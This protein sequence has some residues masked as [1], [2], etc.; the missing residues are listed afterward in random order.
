ML[1]YEGADVN[2]R[3]EGHGTALEIASSKG[4]ALIMQ[5]MLEKNVDIH[6]ER[7]KFLSAI[8]AAASCVNRDLCERILVPLLLKHV[9][10]QALAFKISTRRWRMKDDWETLLPT[11][12]TYNPFRRYREI[13]EHIISFHTQLQTMN[14]AWVHDVM[15]G[16]AMMFA[17]Q[18]E[19]TMMQRLPRVMNLRY[20]LT[21]VD[22]EQRR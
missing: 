21:L 6:I 13:N 8:S 10:A 1:L 15:R 22:L 2:A 9:V 4:N 16:L 17:E 5:L 20:Y 11:L 12:V 3:D 7:G 14:D 19:Y 18:G